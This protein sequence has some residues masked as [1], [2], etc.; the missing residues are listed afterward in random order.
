[1][2]F[3]KLHDQTPTLL[4]L[5][6][7]IIL[8]GMFF[9]N[10]QAQ[11]QSVNKTFAN[12]I[13]EPVVKPGDTPTLIISTSNATNGTQPGQDDF[14]LKEVESSAEFSWANYFLVIGVMF[15]L[16]ALLWSLVW[17]LKRRNALPGTTLLSR[18]A[19]KIEASLPLG[20][21]R[22]LLLVRFLNSRY[23][24]G[25]TDQQI[26]LIKEL[27]DSAE[28]ASEPALSNPIKEKIFAEMLKNASQKSDI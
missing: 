12:E 21:Q 7:L 18:N 6:M 5:G 13:M 19:F 15:L 27:E 24:L 4:L 2:N 26:S 22:T 17:A 20:K 14:F 23:L 16:L 9:F 28:T 3:S 11:A 8:T 25:V 1:M 10:S